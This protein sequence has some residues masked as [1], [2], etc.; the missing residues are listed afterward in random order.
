MRTIFDASWAEGDGDRLVAPAIEGEGSD[1]S[2]RRASAPVPTGIDGAEEISIEEET[3]AEADTPK[4]LPDPGQPTLK[5]LERHRITHNP[6]RTWCKWCIMGR[7]RG[8]HHSASGSSTT[9]VIGID[10]FF[11]TA[12]GVKK[13]SELEIKEDVEGSAALE[14]A[15]TSGDI[16]KCIVIRCAKSKAI[17]AHVVPCKGVDEEDYVAGLVVND[18]AWLGY[19][20]MIIKADNE[21]A[22]QALVRKVIRRAAADCKTLDQVSKEEPAKYDSQSNGLTE[23]G[24]FLVRGIF[25]TLKLCLEARIERQVP[26]RHAIVPWLLEHCCLILN[27]T[28]VGPD[29]MTAWARVRGRPF[30]QRLVG[31]GEKVLHKLPV[32]GP[33]S[34]PDG[35]M[36]T[37]WKE[38]VYLGHSITA[39]VYVTANSDGGISRSRSLYRRPESERWS[40]DALAGITA[41]PWSERE[42]AAPTVAFREAAEDAGGAPA[43][44]APALPRAF[45]ILKADLD[46]HGFTK[47]CPQCDHWDRYGQ[48]RPGGK[49]TTQCRNRIVEAVRDHS[50]K[51]SERVDAHETRVERTTAEFIEGVHGKQDA[52]QRAAAQAAAP[53]QQQQ[54]QQPHAT[55][56]SSAV[57]ASRAEGFAE[58]EVRDKVKSS[59]QPPPGGGGGVAQSAQHATHSSSSSSHGGDVH[60]GDPLENSAEVPMDDD[61]GPNAAGE[62][63]DVDMGFVGLLRPSC[64]DLVAELLIQ[65]INGVGKSYVR[66]RRQ[67]CRKIVSEIYSPPRVTKEIQRGRWRHLA[68]G[69]AL[70]LTVSDPEDGKPWDF[71]LSTKR[72]RARRLFREQ[73]PYLLI[74]SPACKAFSTWMALNRF[75][76]TDPAAV[77][78]AR[79]EAT[80]HL[81]FVASLYQEQLDA[82]RYFLHE[83]PSYATSWELPSIQQLLG[84]PGVQRATGDQCQ[85]GAEAVNGRP[86]KKPSDFMTNSPQVAAALSRRCEGNGGT[87]SRARGGQHQPCEGA[88]AHRAQIYPKGLCRAILHGITQQLR[89]DRLTKAGCLGVQVPD[90]DHEIEHTL[91]GPKQGYSGKFHD[92]LTGQ[93]LRDEL[94]MAARATELTFFTSKAVWKKVPRATAQRTTGRRPISVRW[95]DVNKGDELNPNYRSRLVA[96]QMKAM[97][98]SGQSFFAPAPPL[99]ALRTVLSL[100]MTRVGAN[101]PDWQPESPTRTQISLID[102]K[103]AYFNAAIDKD[104]AP[105]FV[106]LPS[107][108]ADH[109]TMCA[110]LLRHMY[111]TRGA[112]DGWQEEYSTMLVRHGFSQ[113]NACPNLFVHHEKGICCSVHGDD[114]TSCGPKDALDWL[115]ETIATEYDISVD[116]RLGPG[117]HDAKEGRV[118]NRIIRW[119]T[120][121]QMGSSPRQCIEYEADPRQ[122]ERLVA[123]CGL[124]GAKPVATPS[125]KPTFTELE[126]DVELGRE[127]HSAFR[128]AAAR[129]NYVAA[130]RIDAQFSCK[131]IC[132]SMATPTAQAWKALKRLCRYFLSAPRVIY[133]F[134]QQSVEAL[135]VYTDTDWAGCPRTRKS[136]SGGTV[137]LGKHATKHWS[138]TQTSTALSSGE[139]EFAGVIRGAGQGLGYQALLQDLGIKVPLRVWTDSSAAIGICSRQ[140]L[141]K[142]RHLDTHTLW[143][144]QAVRSGRVD[145][146][147]ID[148]EANPADLMTKHTA[149]RGKLEHL[150]QLFNCRLEDGRAASAPQLQ[151]GQGVP[152]PL[153][154]ADDTQAAPARDGVAS[155]CIRPPITGERTS[156]ASGTGDSTGGGVPTMPHLELDPDEL[157]QRHPPLTAPPEE[158]LQ[159][160]VEDEHDAVFMHGNRL[161]REI[162]RE[163]DAHGRRRRAPSTKT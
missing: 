6:F 88:H 151:R 123:E 5:Q 11:I 13:R 126:E 59:E 87:C 150:I 86:I 12:G 14:A 10:Y 97:D 119:C 137:M 114:F 90:D 106:D 113:G 1:E 107:E 32:K 7:A 99:E 98:S 145:L 103:R 104:A 136:T 25:R 127:L 101:Q 163:V 20:A 141:G 57:P 70:D 43:V 131:E 73:K 158:P 66:E 26:V 93:V 128:G 111:G 79:V 63:G 133:A 74:G 68:P 105:T 23:V 75:R 27:T 154:Q 35:N 94:V 160:Y 129:A 117:K 78:R 82:G 17:F 142:L 110:Q 102:V 112:A 64:D 24:V 52:A 47:G 132:R 71:G 81:D 116:P 108:D 109:V 3:S 143:I 84:T 67:A 157:S 54:Q 135:D 34:A 125:V 58:L 134:E 19:T 100:A 96:R 69:F 16:V 62:A 65:Q 77:D 115:E 21:P 46:T 139:A 15:R 51:G 45:K 152:R 36:G 37:R 33:Q 38:S 120:R 39:N 147:K 83:H 140:G 29:G 159:D 41:T 162:Q 161:A 80:L 148:G 121:Q 53:A 89:A 28:S 50:M 72:E 91:Y 48:S 156:E 18:L 60:G 44:A 124:E 76:S 85:Y 92:D 149:S 95:V 42:R 4:T 2:G 118:L 61:D 31:F 146:R 49:H 138:S 122:I 144:Q 130:D 9:A 153:A 22:L 8:A 155:V 30:A 55:S 56:S 40:A